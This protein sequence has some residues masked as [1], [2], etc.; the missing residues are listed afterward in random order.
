MFAIT[1]GSWKFIDGKG[2]GGWSEKGRPED[3]AGQLYNLKSDPSEKTNLF[4]QNP[5]IVHDLKN[6]L[7]EIKN[8]S[9][10]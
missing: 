5:D 1:S 7:N 2:S 10:F 4:D 8:R 3:P 9:S 6:Q